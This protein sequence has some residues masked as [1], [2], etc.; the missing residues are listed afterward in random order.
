M[1]AT[2]ALGFLER[3]HMGNGRFRLRSG[4]DGRWTA[5]PPSDDASGRALLGLGVASVIAPWAEVRDRASALFD[6]AVGFRSPW[7]R[8]TGYACLGAAEVLRAAPGHSSARRLVADAADRL[9]TAAV[10][11][12][13]RWPE[14]RLTYANALLPDAVLTAGIALGR[15]ELVTR[16]LELLD[17]L[18]GHETLEGRFSF[19]PVGGRAPDGPQPAFDQQPIEA[20]AM[21]DACARA[22]AHTGEQKWADA[23]A[24]AG[25]WFL[26]NNDTAIVMFDPATGGGFD[27]LQAD[28]ANRNQG[29]EST[30][31]FVATMAQVA[32]AS[33]APLAPGRA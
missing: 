33:A 4:A 30:L 1:L 9:P 25:S 7:V 27:G 3:A 8:A 21:A 13:W 28:G 16:A 31:A 20:R 18:V 12:R 14:P 29:A 24:L 22:F 5:D 6:A 2:V 17:W 23:L 19:T 26:G 11:G 32:S 15:P 10:P